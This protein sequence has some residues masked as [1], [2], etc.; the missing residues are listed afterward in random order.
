MLVWLAKAEIVIAKPYKFVKAG[1]NMQIL[2]LSMPFWLIYKGAYPM[3]KQITKTTAKTP[4]K[5][6]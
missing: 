4:A 1:L 6:R 2:S 3:I 5:L